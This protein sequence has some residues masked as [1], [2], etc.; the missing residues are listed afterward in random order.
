MATT[1]RISDARKRNRSAIPV[2]VRTRCPSSTPIRT[3]NVHRVRRCFPGDGG[4]RAG[5]RWYRGNS[6]TAVR[7]GPGGRRARALG[8]HPYCLMGIPFGWS[9]SA[10]SAEK[11]PAR[12]PCYAVGPVTTPALSRHR[13]V[14]RTGSAPRIESSGIDLSGID[15]SGIDLSGI[16]LS[17]IDTARARCSELRSSRPC[18]TR[19]P[20]GQGALLDKSRARVVAPSYYE[21]ATNNSSRIRYGE[22]LRPPSGDAHRTLLFGWFAVIV[23]RA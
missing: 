6:R 5:G 22:P 19:G 12:R 8:R 9:L 13:P 21:D 1:P 7:V 16:D 11:R 3:A 15:L 14:V 23:V 20:A 4:R 2:L 18:W 10:P 17:G